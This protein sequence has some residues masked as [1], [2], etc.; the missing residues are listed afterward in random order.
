[1]SISKQ[2]KI[3]RCLQPPQ[4]R[5]ARIFYWALLAMVAGLALFLLLAQKPWDAKLLSSIH[6]REAAGKPWK[7]EH[8]SAVYEW[9]AAAFNLA[10]AAGLLLTLRSWARPLDGDGVVAAEAAANHPLRDRRSWL[11]VALILAVVVGGYFRIQ[12]LDHSLWSDEEYTVRTHIWG[13]MVEADDGGLEY[14]PVTWHDTFFRNKLNN[15]LGFT[16][17]TR[18]LHGAWARFGAT[19]ERPFS[20]PV[21]RALPLLA[22]LGSILLIGIL[23]ARYADPISG[24]GAAFF[25]AINPWHLRY[26]V[27]ARG[28]SGAIF[29]LL[30][31]FLF[32]IPALQRGRWRD[33]LA[34]AGCEL[35][36][37]LCV[38]GS[39][40]ALGLANAVAVALIF[41]MGGGRTLEA[42]VIICG[43]ML[44][45]NVLAAMIFIQLIAPSIPQIADYLLTDHFAGHM[46]LAWWQEV[47]TLFTSGL[48]VSD[49]S[50]GNHAGGAFS[51]EAER[52]PWLRA[53]HML[54]LLALLC[55]GLA[56]AIWKRSWILLPALSTIGGGAIV[57]IQSEITNNSIHPWYIVFVLIG[58]VILI[59]SGVG[60]LGAGLRSL[61][62]GRFAEALPAATF[63][64]FLSLYFLSTITGRRL[65]CETPRQPIRE[66]VEAVRGD[67]AYAADDGGLITGSFGTSKGMITSYDPRNHILDG[68]ARLKALIV[69]A[70]S[71]GK[72]L[73]IYHCGLERA[74]ER[75][76]EMI[77]LMEDPGMF[78]E[79]VPA[80]LGLEELFSYHIYRYVGP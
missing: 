9:W 71:A 67:R 51:S 6:K 19:A 75:E 49:A 20:E 78:E 29:F 30:L 60:G 47:W 31:A 16:I 12:R 2:L 50:P 22:S 38:P 43:R 10:L 1:M 3:P 35:L 73:F 76:P 32:L 46:R 21:L 14:E 18:V 74:R 39:V 63:A 13:K 68:P 66:A 11:L 40:Y 45:A 26:S 61:V 62:P 7:I 65:L 42:R 64:L 48:P 44:V 79:Q 80:I 59:A 58:M 17:P 57:F 37:L 52:L 34:F 5:G 56:L 25:L 36:A 8:Y 72:Q 23:V 15:H 33:W 55:L 53:F 77:A 41:S 24:L 54:G 28:Y 69:E 27:E 4:P 70:S